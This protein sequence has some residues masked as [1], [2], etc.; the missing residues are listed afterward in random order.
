M[1]NKLIVSILACFIFLQFCLAQELSFQ[2]N[3][4]DPYISVSENQLIE[5]QTLKDLN[6]KY[7]SS[8]VSQ[9][10]SVE[11][12]VSHKGK[13]RKATNKTDRLSQA[14]KD[15]LKM[16]DT[17]TDIVINVFYLPKNTLKNNEP[18]K[19]NFTVAVNPDKD[20]QFPDGL[21]QLNKYLKEN[22]IDNIPDDSFKN[23][24]LMA[25]QFTVDEDGQIGNPHVFESV[26]QTYQNEKVEK[27]L[28]AAVQEMP[29]WEPAEFENGT[30]VKQ[31]FVLVVGN[32]ESCLVNFLNTRD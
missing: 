16:A 4:V 3:R 10:I 5:A 32:Q 29:R 1:D 27:I 7:P 17:G 30:K 6:E 15:L 18:K 19:M 13:T 24:D 31:D 28:L 11:V 25:I 21:E 23:Y 12:G 20:A 2:V 9:Y 26:Y 8:W 14:Q 22:A